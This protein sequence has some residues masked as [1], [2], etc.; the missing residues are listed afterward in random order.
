M[1]NS[2][3]TANP[4]ISFDEEPLDAPDLE[5]KIGELMAAKAAAKPYIEKM[6]GLKNACQG[7]VERMELDVG[8]YRVGRFVVTVRDTKET[9]ISFERQSTRVIGFK[10][11]KERKRGGG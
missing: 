2:S 10:P 3:A 1:A 6:R 4:Q 7:D 5:K 9:E 8:S 11:V